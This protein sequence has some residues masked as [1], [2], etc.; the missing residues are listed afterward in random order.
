MSAIQQY[1]SKGIYQYSQIDRFI[2]VKNYMLIRCENR[3]CLMI[4]FSNDA[5]FT[6][7]AMDLV[8]SQ[9][10]ST[11]AVIEKTPVSYKG[12]SFS[13]GTVFVPDEG[14][15]VDESCVNFKLQFV[16]V[17]SGNYKYFVKN[18]KISVVYEKE[19]EELPDF[20]HKTA[21]QGLTVTPVKRGKTGLAIF[22]AILALL[23]VIGLNVYRMCSGYLEAI[24]WSEF[25]ETDTDAVDDNGL[26][27]G[28]ED[29]YR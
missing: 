23:T 12:L 21:V 8:I 15:V 9:L 11:G 29:Q 13:P 7:N 18:G 10:D 6:V 2:S 5:D 28:D 3:K 14:I 24:G 20:H 26:Y 25:D 22:L 4:R 1:I 17:I 19:E 16:T 27:Y